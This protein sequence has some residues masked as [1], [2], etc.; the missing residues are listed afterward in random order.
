MIINIEYNMNELNSIDRKKLENAIDLQKLGKDENSLS[1]LKELI[2]DNP[3]NSKV[4]SFLGLVLAKI[5]D[6]EN[7]ITYLKKAVKLKPTNELLSLTLYISYSEE[8]NYEMAFKVLFDY[9]E[10]QPANL[11]KETLEELLEGL[12][13]GYGDTYKDKIVSYAKKN[14]VFIHKELVN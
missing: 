12:L 4:I 11:F 13:D 10:K 1:I 6:Y 5:N 7:A 14:H 3:N 8:E 9:L 2:K